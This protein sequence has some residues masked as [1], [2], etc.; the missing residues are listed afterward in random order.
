MTAEPSAE[1]QWHCVGPVSALP[2]GQP[3]THILARRPVLILRD[4]E[5][6]FAVEN[7]C[8]HAGSKLDTGV[9]RDA[10]ISCPLHG[11]RFCLRTGA[12]QN[13]PATR[14]IA[15]FETRIR[16]GQLE[17]LVPARQPASGG[18]AGPFGL[19]GIGAG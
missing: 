3:V 12:A 15:V 7:R 5:D 19:G 1:D 10:S 4:G 14:P 8:S 16:D 2:L 11:A 17:V 9:I 6:V 13:P 18:L